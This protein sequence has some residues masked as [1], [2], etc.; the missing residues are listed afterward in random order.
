[1]KPLIKVN[2]KDL[3]FRLKLNY[4]NV[5]S[6][7]M[8]LL[9]RSNNPFADIS[10]KSV[11]TT[12][13]A[14][15]DLDYI[16]VSDTPK[17]ETREVYAALNGL[18]K[19][20][21]AELDKS[22]ELSQYAD[23]IL[24]VP[25]DSYIFYRKTDEGYKFILAGWG[26][27]QAHAAVGEPGG[28]IRRV[29]RSAGV[30]EE[31]ESPR[32]DGA[33]DSGRSGRRPEETG[34]NSD[35]H[36]TRDGRDVGNAGETAGSRQSPASGAVTGNETTANR[37]RKS[38]EKP[39]TAGTTG[40]TETAGTTGTTAE[41]TK[42]KKE[43]HVV[44]KVLNQNMKPVEDEDVKVRTQTGE[45]RGITDEEGMIDVGNLPYHST[46]TVTFPNL[47]SI[48]ERAYEVEPKVEIYEAHIKKYVKYSPV[49]FVEDQN[50]N[51]VNDY[52][53][54]VVVNGQET[55]VNSG[56]DGMV[57]LPTMQEEQR[58]IVIDAANYANSEEYVVTAESVKAPFQFR[59]RRA[60]RTKVG[61]T[62]VDK[63][64][65]P[66]EGV[67]VDVTSGDNPCQQ[68]TGADG[69]AEFPSEVFTP[70][71]MRLKLYVK[72]KGLI[73]SK[74]NFVA[75]TTEYTIQIQDRKKGGGFNWKWLLLLPLLLLI[76]GGIYWL[77]NARKVTTAAEMKKGVVMIFGAGVYY[78]DLNVPD[79]A[80]GPDQK[81]LKAYFVYNDKGEFAGYTFD[82]AI[83]RESAP[84]AWTG[85]G[86]LISED[87]LIATNKHVADPAPPE[88]LAK[89]L[90]RSM[91]EEKDKNQRNV[92]RLNDQLQIIGGSGG[93]FDDRGQQAYLAIRDSMQRYQEQVR[94]L[95]KILNI[96][97]FSIKKEVKLYAAFTGTRVES[98]E[99]LIACSSPLEVGEPGGLMENDLAIIQIK[100]K[101]DIPDDA[102][103]FEVPEVDIMDG[104]IPEDYDVM[105]IGYNAGLNLQPM[106]Y[107]DAIAPQVQRGKITGNS[108]KYRIGFN[109]PTL[110]G[111]SGSPVLN[112]KGELI[113]INNSG[114]DKQGFNYGVRTKYLRELLDKINNKKA[115]DADKGKNK[116]KDN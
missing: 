26:C 74:L 14:P 11:G 53:I 66:I 28:L 76:G 82:E 16:A 108:E 21:R 72:G 38:P 106:D 20:V 8:M 33:A 30:V 57:Q 59:I 78:A 58:F 87:G 101:Q 91:Q 6:R 80:Y 15:D 5:Y 61:V 51:A 25:D 96:G 42:R 48:K 95:D 7:L 94:L 115:G 112:N 70:G 73:N 45:V 92:D 102:Y 83:A 19:K 47:P 97:D 37:D 79:V 107:Q 39:G 55:V 99:D 68:T 62:V 77:L 104:E 13:Y 98:Y 4:N 49:L 85:T 46:F 105:V 110:G 56:S 50:G 23:D 75:D 81:P 100:K 40:T 10:T 35:G 1:M 17:A 31:E 116:G 12:W 41:T 24:D 111:S 113:A 3:S 103:V 34:L 36:E 90:K 52:N 44:L 29:S 18:L 2:N 65:K 71:E 89:M 64:R 69:R 43:Q 32:E 27:K 60:V 9:G 54:K 86:F 84:H 63:D 67:T 22:P 109:A 88:E 114:V 93:L